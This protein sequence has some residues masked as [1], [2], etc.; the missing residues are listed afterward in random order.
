MVQGCKLCNINCSDP[1]FF[2]YITG[3]IDIKI[4]V[5]IPLDTELVE[6]LQEGCVWLQA[7]GAATEVSRAEDLMGSSEKVH[8]LQIFLFNFFL[9]LCFIF[10]LLVCTFSNSEVKFLGVHR[11]VFPSSGLMS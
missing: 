1:R 7:R 10:F 5:D 9:I 4:N 8:T 11:L 6:P 3:R 2:L